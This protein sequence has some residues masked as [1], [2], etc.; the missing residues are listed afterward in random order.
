MLS[1]PTF[2]SPQLEGI[3]TVWGDRGEPTE[4]L[5][6]RKGGGGEGGKG[7]KGVEKSQSLAGLGGWGGG[8]Q[9]QW[10]NLKTKFTSKGK[11]TGPQENLR[12]IG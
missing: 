4:G 11:T 8:L 10:Q 6:R 5:G 7:G 2:P 1:Q 12:V 3:H 9:K